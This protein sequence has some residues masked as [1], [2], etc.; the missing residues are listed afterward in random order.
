MDREGVAIQEGE[1]SGKGMK[2][3]RVDVREGV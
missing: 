2:G 3:K 1:I